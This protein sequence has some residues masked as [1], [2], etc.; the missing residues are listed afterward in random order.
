M[1]N[2]V[3]LLDN[4][5]VPVDPSK[6]IRVDKFTARPWQV[7]F[8]NAYFKHRDRY[9]FY[10]I[11]IHRRGGKDIAAWNIALHEAI[12]TPGINI[13]YWLPNFAQCRRVIWDASTTEGQRIV[14]HYL[15][16]QLIRSMNA[17]TMQIR[18]TN[19]SLISLMG[20]TS[21]D[22]IVGTNPRLC[23]FSEY[24]LCSPRVLPLVLPILRANNGKAIF[25]STPR[26]R[27]HWY[28]LFTRAQNSPDW[29]TTNL[30]IEDT[31]LID[32]K[33]V[34]KDIDDGLIS[35]DM[36]QQE[37]Y[38]SFSLGLMGAFYGR[39]MDEM[40]LYE[41]IGSVPWDPSLKTHL[42]ADLGWNDFTS[43]IWFQIGK[44]G[45][46]RV[47]D[48][49][50]NNHQDLAHYANIIRSKPYWPTMGKMIFPHDVKVHELNF[51]ISRLDRLRDL[52]INATL[53][54]PLPFHD[55]VEVVRSVLARTY[56]DELQCKVLIKCLENY[57]RKY[58]EEKQIYWDEP[59]KSEWN[60]GA[61]AFRY[62]AVSINKLT[63][64][65]TKEAREIAFRQAKYGNNLPQ[66]D[67]NLIIPGNPFLGRGF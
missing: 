38:C 58:D 63:D 44:M 33:Q 34:Q 36:A 20:S 3:T 28:D 60:H 56:I 59:I 6:I 13:Q 18:L 40:R 54:N 30:T 4:K 26:S 2:E 10:A 31:G 61:D 45:D 46:I 62:L 47:I 49:Y 27:N 55:G 50:Q 64:G 14:E 16:Q 22:N 5:K 48:Y 15:P 32:A 42:S 25:L 53:A 17:S 12:R 66:D 37:Y 35:W 24:A 57:R 23:I 43:L 65:L 7:P 39:Q 8:Y 52:G 19:G 29:Y 11:N 9:K 21:I 41:R 67:N 51:G 1:N